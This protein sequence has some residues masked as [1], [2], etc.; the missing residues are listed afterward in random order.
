VEVDGGEVSL[1]NCGRTRDLLFWPLVRRSDVPASCSS[2]EFSLHAK[3]S[4]LVTTLIEYNS[5]A[6]L[7]RQTEKSE[8]RD[9]SFISTGRGSPP[10]LN[11]TEFFFIHSILKHERKLGKITQLEH[12][13]G[14]GY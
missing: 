1:T 2:R 13:G 4:D 9:I 10:M 8:G 12:I 14:F 6:F 7:D 3:R 11:W 5:S